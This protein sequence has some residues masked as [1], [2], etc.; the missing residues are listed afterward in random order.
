MTL[1]RGKG[2][3]LA[4][5]ARPVSAPNYFTM[6]G[7]LLSSS[8]LACDP[9]KQPPAN[10]D[11]GEVEFEWAPGHRT[12]QVL[13]DPALLDLG[14]WLWLWLVAGDRLKRTTFHGSLRLSRCL[15][16]GFQGHGIRLIL[17]LLRRCEVQG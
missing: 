1:R 14:C 16:C 8:L 9:R 17:H 2:Q 4:R 12:L 11:P 10:H 13:L 5:P 3:R 15:G 6:L 7:R